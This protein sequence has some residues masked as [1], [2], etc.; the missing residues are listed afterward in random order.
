[1]HDEQNSI[2]NNNEELTLELHK[3]ELQVNKKIIDT[4]TVN[5]YKKTY[6]VE[7]QILVPVTYEELII[8][9]KVP[10]EKVETI[11]IP[12]SEERIEITKHPIIIEDVE[13]YK[14]KIEEYIQISETVKEENI[15]ID[16][17]GDVR[18]VVDN[19]TSTV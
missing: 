14:E 13:I 5:V 15:Q 18:V 3:E 12:L 9:K 6:T 4:A 11:S 8:E 17:V 10:N 1:M 2:H 19:Q 16:T 7:K